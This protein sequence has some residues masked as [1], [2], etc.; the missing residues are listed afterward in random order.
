MRNGLIMIAS[1]SVAL[2][3][4]CSEGA[5]RSD[6]VTR[7]DSAGVEVV[8]NLQP[9][10]DT[11]RLTTPEVRIGHDET[12]TESV[13]R[14]VHDV[15]FA[16]GGGVI[17]VDGGKRVVL[18]DSAGRA[19]R[20]LGREGQGP[21]EYRGVRWALVRSDTIA[22]W[23]VVARRLLFFREN[24]E[25]LG[26]L[27]MADNREGR[28]LRPFG[29]GWLDEAEAG[30]YEDTAPARGFIL[31][32]GA[33]GTVRDTILGP[34]AIPEIGWK[35]TDPK[36]GY[37]SMVNPPALAISPAWTVSKDAIVWA[38]A[39]RP[40]IHVHDREGA[41]KRIIEVP[42]H[43]GPPSDAQRD[44][45]IA[46]LAD[47][48]GMSAEAAARSRA[49][50]TFADTVPVITRVIV[51]GD[52][53]MWAGGFAATEPF[54]FVGPIWDVLEPD[55]RVARRVEFPAGFVLHAVRGG[56][57]VGARTLESGVPTVEVYRV[58]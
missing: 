48:Y 1:G 2:L 36:T 4:A 41:L 17:V 16:P 11:V 46:T 13:F 58:P 24:G 20:V 18:F 43:P 3:G 28:G 12:Q 7:T 35:V 6:G 29:D 8:R 33:D 31:R 44:A 22:L 15:A 5:G 56:R 47:R 45:F 39:K 14:E 34:Y 26:Q 50:T 53:R 37:G 38:S 54:S 40:R 27:A 21:G 55:G 57:A 10:R 51:E 25:A 42:H 52:G 9:A 32:R 30:Q 49:S 23:D 19:P